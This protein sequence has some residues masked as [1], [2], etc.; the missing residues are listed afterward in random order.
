[1]PPI[2]NKAFS[3]AIDRAREAEEKARAAKAIAET[4]KAEALSIQAQWSDLVDSFLKLRGIIQMAEATLSNAQARTATLET[5]LARD[6]GEPLANEPPMLIAEA[7]ALNR[8]CIPVL[9]KAVAE[10]R[11]QF[12]EAEAGLRAFA[13][14]NGIPDTVF[15]DEHSAGANQESP[16]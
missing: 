4:F 6:L 14:K 15:V 11:R 13:K 10:K 8:L 3:E 1:M 12:D 5:L 9:E 16:R 7:L 2:P